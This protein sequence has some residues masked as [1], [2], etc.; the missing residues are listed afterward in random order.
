V[1]SGY[2]PG[3]AIALAESDTIEGHLFSGSSVSQM[4]AD[5]P[6]RELKAKAIVSVSFQ[7]EAAIPPLP[8]GEVDARS[9][10][11]GEGSPHR[12]DLSY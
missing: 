9:R 6:E 12:A 11:S 1:R 8:P 3:F 10:A 2:L 7:T 4:R 5:E